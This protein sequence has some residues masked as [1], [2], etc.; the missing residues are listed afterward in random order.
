MTTRAPTLP[1]PTNE[2]VHVLTG[3]AGLS[4]RNVHVPRKPAP[5]F[6]P[7]C[8]PVMAGHLDA[9]IRTPSRGDGTQ[10]PECAQAVG[11]PGVPVARSGGACGDERGAVLAVGGVPAG[12]YQRVNRTSPTQ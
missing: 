7:I 6:D 2:S 5:G 4:L 9:V 1:K 8:A 12:E 3:A 10:V 11:M